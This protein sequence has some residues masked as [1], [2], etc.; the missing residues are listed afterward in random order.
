MAGCH[1]PKTAI[2]PG[3][4]GI[5]SDVFVEVYHSADIPKGIRYSTSSI[6][7]P[8]GRLSNHHDRFFFGELR[9]M[10]K[11]N[12]GDRWRYFRTIVQEGGGVTSQLKIFP[13]HDHNHIHAKTTKLTA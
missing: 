2:C 10:Q 8:D 5:K 3:Q 12:R 4:Y 7:E 11:K 6:R 9:Q 13:A 1:H